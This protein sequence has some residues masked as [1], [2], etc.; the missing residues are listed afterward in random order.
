MRPITQV[1]RYM[2]NGWFDHAAHRQ[3]ACADCH[4]ASRSNAASDVLLPNRA[5]CRS[6]HL[7][8]GATKPKV[9]S[10]CVM[11]HS[12]HQTGLAPASARR[13]DAADVLPVSGRI[14]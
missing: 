7:G 6:C 10:T 8:E 4:A 9:P 14:N 3:T 2:P 12:Y 13:R 11:C 1:S 5:S